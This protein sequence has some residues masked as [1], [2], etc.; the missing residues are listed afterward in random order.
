MTFKR[1]SKLAHLVEEGTLI[2]LCTT[3]K[4]L[5]QAA[6]VVSFHPAIFYRGR[7]LWLR[8]PFREA[9]YARGPSGSWDE[10]KMTRRRRS[11]RPPVYLSVTSTL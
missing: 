2:D 9:R 4:R 3:Q 7:H 6:G 11:H 10:C 5:R 1:L 8:E